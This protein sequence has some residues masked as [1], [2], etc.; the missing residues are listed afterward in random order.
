MHPRVCTR[1]EREVPEGGAAVAA[2]GLSVQVVGLDVGGDLGLPLVS[3]VQQLLLVVQQL[4]VR[5][6]RVLEVGTLSTEDTA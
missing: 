6:C 2:V 1:L 4:F 5:L 3:V